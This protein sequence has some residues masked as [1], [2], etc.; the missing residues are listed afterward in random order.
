MTLGNRGTRIVF[1]TTTIG[2]GALEPRATIADDGGI[3][4]PYIKSGIS[5]ANAGAVANELWS[6][7]SDGNTIK[8]GV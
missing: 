7:T 6:D 1:C 8:L 4:T 3:H 2:T 5:Q